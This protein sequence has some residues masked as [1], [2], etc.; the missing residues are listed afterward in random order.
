MN[1]EKKYGVF[2]GRMHPIHLGHERVIKKMIHE[3]GEENCLVVIG[4]SNTKTSLRHFFSYE[5]RR[6][7]IRTLFP[8]VRIVGIPDFERDEEWLL[9]LDDII[10]TAHIELEK[11]TFYG[12]SDKDIDFFINKGRNIKIIDRYSQSISNNISATMVREAIINNHSVDEFLNEKIKHDVI[13]IFKKKWREIN[14]KN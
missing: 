9:A 10:D 11:T 13:N 8:E 3:C 12:G 7:F 5:E 4:S 6:N 1:S 14:Q 2:V